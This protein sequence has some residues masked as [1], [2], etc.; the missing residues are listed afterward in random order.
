VTAVGALGSAAVAAPTI[1]VAPSSAPRGSAVTISGSVPVSGTAS[2]ASGDP[3]QLTSTADL[4]PP[5]GFGPQTARDASGNFNTTYTIPSTTR[6]ATYSIGVRCGGGA[7]GVSA[8]LQVTQPATT[9]VAP[10]TTSSTTTTVAQTPT[11]PAVTTTTLVAPTNDSSDRTV[12]I[13]L[14]AIA[15]L[16]GAGAA[17]FLYRR[18]KAEDAS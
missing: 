3:V 2:C 5:D 10:A 15:L 12:W 17:L 14:G 4:F 6:P 9:T 11:A 7:I 13:V 8:T 1:T 16:I 18:R